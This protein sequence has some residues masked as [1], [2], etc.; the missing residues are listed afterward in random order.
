MLQLEMAPSAQP[1]YETS[2]P[3]SQNSSERAAAQR[4]I[5]A[6]LAPSSVVIEDSFCFDDGDADDRDSI[7]SQ[8]S[9]ST[10][11][12]P[13]V[14][15]QSST[16]PV[17]SHTHTTNEVTT[18]ETARSLS[19]QEP[20]S[21]IRPSLLGH[22]SQVGPITSEDGDQ[23]SA[24]RPSASTNEYTLDLNTRTSPST[25]AAV[26]GSEKC[27]S[28][29]GVASPDHSTPVRNLG[30]DSRGQITNSEPNESPSTPAS[31]AARNL[32]TLHES[33]PVSHV[34][35]SS[36][37][38][39]PEPMDWVL[40]INEMDYQY[41]H[42]VLAQERLTYHNSVRI[43][44]EH[45]EAKILQKLKSARTVLRT[46]RQGISK[47]RRRSLIASRDAKKRF[48]VAR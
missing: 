11:A 6:H 41:Y 46:S 30:S 4:P 3:A 31:E 17:T 19:Q 5:D 7:P 9:R 44:D 10:Q 43:V 25:H 14:P 8:H 20:E 36:H 2:P 29:V 12:P 38:P 37:V 26:N 40:R 45:R 23:F 48:A 34:R 16:L 35:R 33:S 22:T 15:D 13:S 24:I 18:Q 42:E 28:R 47:S 27:G 32:P 39:M 21:S 1:V